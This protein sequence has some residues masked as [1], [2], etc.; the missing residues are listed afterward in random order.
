MRIDAFYL[1]GVHDSGVL[2]AI[3]RGQAA[4]D[5]GLFVVAR[6]E[7]PIFHGAVPFLVFPAKGVLV[8]FECAL[9]VF[10]VDIEVY[11]TWR[12]VFFL[13]KKEASSRVLSVF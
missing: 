5:A 2:A 1:N 12:G 13:L 6:H 11:G 9:R 3:A 7:H 4:V 8:E 10:G